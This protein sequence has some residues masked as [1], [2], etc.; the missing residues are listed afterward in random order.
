MTLDNTVKKEEM[1][2]NEVVLKR[3]SELKQVMDSLDRDEIDPLTQMS[4]I[5]VNSRLS[6]AEISACLRFDELVRLGILPDDLGLTRQKKRLSISKNGEGR[7]EKVEIVKGERDQETGGG[8]KRFM[9]GLF[10]P[11]G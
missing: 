1:G 9:G 6:D 4:S 3:D 11:K 8:F 7:R 10:Q 2:D 5:D